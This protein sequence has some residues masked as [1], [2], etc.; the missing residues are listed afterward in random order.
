[1]NLVIILTIVFVV[2]TGADAFYFYLGSKGALDKIKGTNAGKKVYDTVHGRVKHR[3]K[4]HSFFAV[5]GVKLLYG[6]A[7]IGLIYLGER[8]PFRKFVF[9]DIIVNF[10]VCA[11]IYS[12][13]SYFDAKMSNILNNISYV[14]TQVLLV[15]TGLV[16]IYLLQSF[17]A[18]RGIKL[19]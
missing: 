18:K 9:Y 6:L 8:M 15:A 11:I 19:I 10:C 1:M 7:I 17:L 12:F 2:L 13:V 3:V 5:V 4:H 14:Q 16:I